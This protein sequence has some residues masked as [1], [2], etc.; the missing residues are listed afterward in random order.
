MLFFK[1]WQQEF[2]PATKGASSVF[3]S[4]LR[5]KFSLRPGC[6]LPDCC[7]PH[8]SLPVPRS[9]QRTGKRPSCRGLAITDW[10]SETDDEAFDAVAEEGFA[11]GDDLFQ[12]ERA[13]VLHPL[14][15]QGDARVVE[16]AEHEVLP[17]RHP[18]WR[19][20]LCRPASGW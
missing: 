3:P 20:G 7:E 15:V 17:R 18:D 13:P 11:L 19:R 10:P 5:L 8:C 1:I 14:L 12:G 2:S 6:F 9:R 16:K 4:I